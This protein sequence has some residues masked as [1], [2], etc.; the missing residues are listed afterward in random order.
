MEEKRKVRHQRLKNESVYKNKVKM[1]FKPSSSGNILRNIQ[2]G[3]DTSNENTSS[4]DEVQPLSTISQCLKYAEEVSNLFSDGLKSE[5][6]KW[7]KHKREDEASDEKVVW[8]HAKRVA[9]MVA[10]QNKNLDRLVEL[11]VDNVSKDCPNYDTKELKDLA[12]YE[13]NSSQDSL[14]YKG[15]KN[16]YHEVMGNFVTRN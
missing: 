8:K 10:I 4:S 2:I 9:K 15:K 11:I 7:K 5:K 3:D 14:S 6:K 12:H 1:N 13:L 16:N